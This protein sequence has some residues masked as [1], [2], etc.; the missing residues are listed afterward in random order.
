V[1]P[2]ERYATMRSVLEVPILVEKY[3]AKVPSVAADAIMI[4][5]EDSAVPSHKAEARDLA[6]AALADRDYFGGRRVVV[7]A[8]NLSTPW[9]RDDL[10]ALASAPGEFLVSYPKVVD[11]DELA[12]VAATLATRP[13]GAPGLHVMIETAGAVSSLAAIASFPGVHGLHFGYV[14]Y[15]ADLGSQPFDRRG[16]RLQPEVGEYAKARIAVAAAAN[17]LFATGGTLI[18]E[19]RDQEKVRHF[20][21]SWADCGY[22]ACIALS[23]AHLEIVNSE[24]GPTPDQ[25]VAARQVCERYEQAVHDGEPAAVVG[26]R[27]VTMPDYRIASLLLARVGERRADLVPTD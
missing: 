13:G 6:V 26:G 18:P 4:D 17:G 10:V 7:R 20:V 14:D 22:T 24:M 1:T 2:R 25:V 27:V 21:R 8:N 5:L 12:D 11:V 3:W 23:P 19:F 15:A 16:E 9:G